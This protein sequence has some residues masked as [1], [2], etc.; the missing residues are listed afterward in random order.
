[1]LRVNRGGSWMYRRGD[2]YKREKGGNGRLLTSRT[3]SRALAPESPLVVPSALSTELVRLAYKDAKSGLFSRTDAST[4]GNM[5]P[6]AG[7][8][9][10]LGSFAGFCGVLVVL[11]GLV[12]VLGSFAVNIEGK[13]GSA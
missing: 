2:K 8:A 11:V 13:E 6:R 9:S 5:M 12:G 3:A 4:G 10:V 1:M 7:D